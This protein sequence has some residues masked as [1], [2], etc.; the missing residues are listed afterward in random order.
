MSIFAKLNEQKQNEHNQQLAIPD[1]IQDEYRYLIEMPSFIQDYIMSRIALGFSKATIQ[2]YLY[3][4]KY[5]FDYVKHAT[6]EKDL[7]MSEISLDDFI[8]IDQKGVENYIQHLSLYAENN[9]K[10]VNRKLSALKSLFD[11]LKQRNLVSTN[12]VEGIERPKVA[13][14]DPIY[15]QR[16]EYTELLS[17]I[18][19]D[20]GLTIRQRPF[21]ERFKKRDVAIIHMLIMTGVRI[22]EL[23][24]IRVKDL[25]RIDKEIT[26][27]GKGNK[28]RTIPLSEG[29]LEMIDEYVQSI[30]N[31]ARPKHAEES[32]FIGFD[33]TTKAYKNNVTINAIQ[34]MIQ[35]HIKRAKK[36]LPFLAYKPITAHKLRHSFATELVYRGVDVLT[37]QNLLGHESV[38]TTQI[39]AHVQKD[40]KKKAVSLLD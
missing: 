2:R 34:K 11:Y 18:L 23:C 29:T 14:R 30:P 7:Q 16:D 27:T 39:Y 1:H 15:L 3:D 25:N 36:H 19:S 17:F 12:P 9:A 21:H 4:Y 10:T 8:E 37:V 22:S 31:Y 35:R 38:A 28:Q 26:V 32:L 24:R 33:F 40:M 13:K 5:F 6:G 20:E